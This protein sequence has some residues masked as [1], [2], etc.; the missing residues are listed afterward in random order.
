MNGI[1]ERDNRSFGESLRAV[2]YTAQRPVDQWA[3]FHDAIAYVQ[4]RSPNRLNP[5][6]ISSYEKLYGSKPKVYY[7]RILGV[8]AYVISYDK[9]SMKS[10]VRIVG[11]L[12]GYAPN[13]S[14]GYIIYNPDSGRCVISWTVNTIFDEDW[15]FRCKR[16]SSRDADYDGLLLYRPNDDVP[17][18]EIQSSS[19]DSLPSWVPSNYFN[20]LPPPSVSLDSP[21][22]LDWTGLDEDRLDST[23][24]HCVTD[25][26]APRTLHRFDDGRVVGQTVETLPPGVQWP[27]PLVIPE[28]SHVDGNITPWDV[29]RHPRQT[30]PTTPGSSTLMDTT[31]TAEQPVPSSSEPPISNV[32]NAVR[33]VLDPAVDPRT[34]AHPRNVAFDDSSVFNPD[35]HSMTDAGTG[36]T[37]TG[38]SGASRRNYWKNLKKKKKKNKSMQTQS[39]SP[40]SIDHQGE[41]ERRLASLYSSASLHETSWLDRATSVVNTP[42]FFANLIMLGLCWTAVTTPDLGH[43]CDPNLFREIPFC[44]DQIKQPYPHRMVSPLDQL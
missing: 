24:D 1:A 10:R 20:P 39:S 4:F 2:L 9:A 26:R 31:G 40:S 34:P 13:S 22:P 21:H 38:S 32:N 42:R 29:A 6:S 12:G 11:Y 43:P 7:F 30:V 33:G 16:D 15:V 14:P 35:D 23:G 28:D 18:F 44:P 27:E 17:S 5:G 36:T 41:E 25:V 3:R 37:A 19:M 8:P